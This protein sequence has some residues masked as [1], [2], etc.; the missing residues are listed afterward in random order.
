MRTEGPIKRIEDIGRYAEAGIIESLQVSVVVSRN[1][2]DGVLH[3]SDCFL[4]SQE[5]ELW[6]ILSW[7]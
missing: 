5:P 7:P 3:L 4:Y 6:Y 2:L 1:I